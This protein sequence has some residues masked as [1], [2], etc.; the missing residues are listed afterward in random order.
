[1]LHWIVRNK[2]WLFSGVLIV[3]PVTVLGWLFVQKR[4]SIRQKQKGGAGSTNVQ[5]GT[6]GSKPDE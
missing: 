6:I 5:V 2:E 1:M 4:L 3:V